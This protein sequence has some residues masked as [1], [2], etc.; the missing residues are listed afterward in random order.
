M[1]RDTAP[2]WALPLLILLALAGAGIGWMLTS[3]HLSH[4][5]APWKIFEAVCGKDGGGCSG[6][7]SSSWAVLPGGIPLA[8][9]GFAY[10]GGLG[11]WYLVVGLANR[12]GRFWQ[13]LPFAAQILGALGSLY[14]LGVMV[15]QIRSFCVWCTLSHLINFALLFVAWRAWP[16]DDGYSNEPARPSIR[17]GLAGILLVIALAALTFQRII[18]ERAQL[19]T[20]QA[21]RYAQTFYG[22]VDLQRYLYQLPELRG[23]FRAR[24]AAALRQ[25]APPRSR[26]SPTPDREGA[27]IRDMMRSTQ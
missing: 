18:V 20:Q 27:K 11:L 3:Y 16:R 24:A 5:Q 9:L 13:G 6:V 19:L 26:E 22:D 4:G 8:A 25:S 23:I 12:R 10:F 14:F 1:R 21:N 7:L 17:L 2:A 15:V